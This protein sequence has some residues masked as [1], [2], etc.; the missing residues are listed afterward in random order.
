M[1]TLTL[2]IDDGAALMD[3]ELDDA[4]MQLMSG[5]SGK[6]LDKDALRLS[7]SN[8]L[9]KK[10]CSTIPFM[11]MD[12]ESMTPDTLRLV[13]GM[14]DS[15]GSDR[16]F[17][18]WVGNTEHFWEVLSQ[19]PDFFV[20]RT[21]KRVFPSEKVDSAEWRCLVRDT[22]KST[23]TSDYTRMAQTGSA[24]MTAAADRHQGKTSTDLVQLTDPSQYATDASMD[25]MVNCIVSLT[26]VNLTA[27]A[28]LFTMMCC[29]VHFCHVL[30][31]PTLAV[32]I[33]ENPVITQYGRYYASYIISHEEE[34]TTIRRKYNQGV[35]TTQHR[36][37][38]TLK[39]CRQMAPSRVRCFAHP[40]SVT[41]C[42][43]AQE[44]HLRRVLGRYHN[45]RRD[46]TNL[47]TVTEFLRRLHQ[48]T[49]GIFEGIDLR[50]LGA[51]VSGSILIP[52]CHV[53][54]VENTANNTALSKSIVMRIPRT[55][56]KGVTH[57]T[58]QMHEWMRFIERTELVYPGYA[59]MDE[60]EL[61]ELLS[62]DE[63]TVKSYEGTHTNDLADVDLSI[64]CAN[65]EAFDN[66]VVGLHIAIC[67]RH[68]QKDIRIRRIKTR[69]GYKYRM[70]GYGMSR[71]V[72]IFCTNKAPIDLVRGYHLPCV[73]MFWDEGYTK[74]DLQQAGAHLQGPQIYNSCYSALVSGINND[75]R[76]FGCNK[77][78]LDVIIKYMARGI[79]TS[80]NHREEQIYCAYLKQPGCKWVPSTS[81][82]YGLDEF[83][84]G[85]RS[86]LL[87]ATSP[88]IQPG[89]IVTRYDETRRATLMCKACSRGYGR[90]MDRCPA[91]WNMMPEV[92]DRATRRVTPPDL[93]T[94]ESMAELLGISR[95]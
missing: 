84:H 88:I 11:P 44:S 26:R 67:T 74:A 50:S 95:A 24:D 18:T 85:L 9:S 43:G 19:V 60:A 38:Q 54:T 86:S 59:S 73:R 52:C 61:K 56:A 40:T 87:P 53:S 41:P 81:T 30:F 46:P 70:F 92:Y 31:H 8:A 42:R 48:V 77:I 93:D 71:P 65:P 23:F 15:E 63:D 55:H 36:F 6:R 68:P 25:S 32:F 16:I 58:V 57:T 64:T 4:A 17:K 45:W 10:I 22:K 27:G 75:Y 66:Q 14:L 69:S 49:N 20:E 37:V 62:S 1:T 90:D 39:V 72:D 82:R 33:R 34:L 7:S 80:F 3:F 83:I 79:T 21:A 5:M 12:V 94:I 13:F 91:V 76:W 29:S 51:A 28:R 2:H 78:P 89:T 35:V 47:N